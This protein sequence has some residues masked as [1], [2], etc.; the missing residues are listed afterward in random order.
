MNHRNPQMVWYHWPIALT[1][2]LGVARDR[3]IAVSKRRLRVKPL[4]SFVIGVCVLEM[5]IISLSAEKVTDK[6]RARS[7][8]GTGTEHGRA[9]AARRQGDPILIT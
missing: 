7:Q 9:F 8:P 6:T 2:Y 5:S 3:C 4:A 1:E